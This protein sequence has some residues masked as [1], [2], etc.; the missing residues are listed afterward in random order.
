MSGINAASPVGRPN[1][2]PNAAAT[3]QDQAQGKVD[4]GKVVN[5]AINQVNKQQNAS[6]V[7]VQNLLTGKSQDILPVVAA[8]AKADLSFKLLMGVRNKVIEAYKQTMNMQV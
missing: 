7:A 6:E 2:K 4:F 1:W 8:V 3:G 5:N